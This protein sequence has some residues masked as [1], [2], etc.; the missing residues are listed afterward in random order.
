MA[1]QQPANT[2]AKYDVRKGTATEAVRRLLEVL[3]FGWIA[4]YQECRI[5]S[6]AKGRYTCTIRCV[7]STG[8]E[9]R[10]RVI[11]TPQ[12]ERGAFP[13]SFADVRMTDVTPT[14]QDREYHLICGIKADG[15]MRTSNPHL[16]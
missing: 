8:R 14:T 13:L 6:L 2:N 3:G 15:T 1:T 7:T 12:R 11:L 5:R 10:A 16:K 4:V 9:C